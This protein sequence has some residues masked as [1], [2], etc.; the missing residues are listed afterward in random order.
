MNPGSPAGG[1]DFDGVTQARAVWDFTTGDAALFL[2]R[3]GLIR[4]AAEI[5][6]QR[7]AGSDFV[8]LLHGPVMKFVV[9]DTAATSLAGETVPQQA[10]IHRALAALHG[11]GARIEVC[12]V[13]MRRRGVEES[14]LMDFCTVEENVFANSIALQNRGYAVMHVQ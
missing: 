11:L 3:L 4:S 7:G 13:S 8:L 9:R 6:R 1:G 5:F 14:N 12:R 2:D 10:E